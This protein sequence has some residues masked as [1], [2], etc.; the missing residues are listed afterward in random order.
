MKEATPVPP[1]SGGVLA[2][3]NVAGG[4]LSFITK[5]DNIYQV[6]TVQRDECQARIPGS[7]LVKGQVWY[8]EPWSWHIGLEDIHIMDVTTELCDGL[9]SHAGEDLY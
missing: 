8:N 5:S 4:D 1:L 3:F 2:T 6:L 9:P 7:R